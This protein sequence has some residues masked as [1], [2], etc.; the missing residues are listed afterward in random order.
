MVH[1]VTLLR[2]ISV[3]SHCSFSEYKA[4]VACVGINQARQ[5]FILSFKSVVIP[6]CAPTT[7]C[8]FI[9]GSSYFF[10]T[11]AD[12]ALCLTAHSKCLTLTILKTAIP[13][14]SA[15]SY[16]QEH[17]ITLTRVVS[18]I[19]KNIVVRG[20]HALNPHSHS[21]QVRRNSLKP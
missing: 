15:I 8:S 1:S 7:C 20:D 12:A 10:P 11:H 5:S 4:G 21:Q 19:S 3:L 18:P 2:G 9:N 13:H 17:N 16:A 14:H 6:A